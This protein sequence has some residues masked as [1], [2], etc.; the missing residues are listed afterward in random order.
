LFDAPTTNDDSDDENGIDYNNDLIFL[1]IR[2]YIAYLTTIILVQS[3]PTNQLHLLSNQL[4]TNT[5]T[6][7]QLSTWVLL[8]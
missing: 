3:Y 5:N 6:H 7:G 2:T 8:F 1:R 4:A